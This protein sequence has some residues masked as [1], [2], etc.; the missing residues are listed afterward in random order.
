MPKLEVGC[1][2]ELTGKNI[3][4][5]VAFIGQTHFETGTWVGIILDEPK[6]KNNGIVKNRQGVSKTYFEV[7]I[8]DN[9]VFIVIV[10]A[11][12]DFLSSF[13]LV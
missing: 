13:K 1:R 5:N 2:V 6:G 9:N 12:T 8:F 11:V 10:H 7:I 4:G 3:Q